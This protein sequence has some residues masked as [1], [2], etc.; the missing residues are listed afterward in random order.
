MPA[1]LLPELEH[2]VVET[3]L[4][5]PEKLSGEEETLFFASLA[6]QMI[7]LSFFKA[8]TKAALCKLDHSVQNLLKILCCS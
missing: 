8:L 5:I 2:P 1:L 4:V 7:I 6:L 3:L